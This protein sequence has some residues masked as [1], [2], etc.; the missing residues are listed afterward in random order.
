MRFDHRRFAW[1]GEVTSKLLAAGGAQVTMTYFKGE[2]DAKNIANEIVSKGGKADIMHWNVLDPQ[3]TRIQNV[4]KT[5]PTHLYY[6]ATPRIAANR[7]EFSEKLFRSFCDYYVSRFSSTLTFFLKHFSTVKKV[8]Y[9]SSIFIEE[10]P[11]PFSEYAAAK[12]AGE[13]LCSFFEKY[14]KNISIYRPRLPK[15]A[16]DQTVSVIP[17]DSSD[18]VPIMLKQLRYFRDYSRSNEV[19]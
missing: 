11:L 2:Q 4:A 5:S 18:P 10:Q 3:E 19:R 15:M 1:I 12:S 7:E 16:T 13:V 14:E 6:F 9:P 8:F 17:S